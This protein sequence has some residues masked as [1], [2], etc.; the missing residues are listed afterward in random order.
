MADNTYR[1]FIA[2]KAQH[3]EG[4]KRGIMQDNF[5]LYLY[6]THEIYKGAE[7]YGS[8]NFIV[9]TSKPAV[10]YPDKLYCINGELYHYM[11]ILG[12]VKLTSRTVFEINNATDPDSIPTSAAVTNA[13]K[14][15]IGSM[16]NSITGMAWSSTSGL[17]T[18]TRN[19]GYSENI[20]L[21]GAVTH[22]SYS[23][24]ERILRLPVVG[25]NT[26]EIALGEDTHIVSGHIAAD[27]E[28]L[29]LG[30][31]DNDEAVYIDVSKLAALVKPE[32]VKESSTVALKF[33][34]DGIMSAE[35]KV[36]AD[37][38]NAIEVREDGLF[39]EQ[40]N[41]VLF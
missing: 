19:S 9:C 20:E 35:V 16:D 11:D 6:D 41:L 8:D 28:T 1:F 3:T 12:W 37:E 29:I 24:R 38:G 13:I 32:S 7:K 36:S 26:V 30:T 31:Q 10:A 14:S 27:G 33:D 40:N 4:V 21:S 18:V 2:T 5:L 23:E 34:E 22:P 15:A 25:G 17:V 39:V